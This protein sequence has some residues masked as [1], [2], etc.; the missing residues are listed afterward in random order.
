MSEPAIELRGVNLRRG[1][2][3]VLEDIDLRVERGAFLAVLGPN[4]SGKTTL[5]RTILGLIE[6]QRGEVRVL[7]SSA[8][9][10]RG[11]VGYVPQ[12]AAFDLDFPIRSEEVVL[13]GR[14]ARRRW[15]RPYDASDR[16]AAH[17]ALDTMEVEH[18]AD[19]PVG[20][21]SGG[22][23]QRVLIARA[24]AMEPALLLLDEPTAGMTINE[25]EKTVGLLKRLNENATVIVV[26]HDMN[27]IRMIAKQ[28]TVMHEGEVF[29]EGSMEAIEAN[30]AVRDIYLGKGTHFAVRQ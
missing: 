24:L 3:Q 9:E 5:L 28:V 17:R 26:E 15:L 22:E 29:A 16:L 2:V 18:L 14:L 21:L 19:R 11:R 6:P 13:M 23:L 1:G 10:A 8:R 30:E 12:R 20:A 7:G 25:V 27:F 4:G